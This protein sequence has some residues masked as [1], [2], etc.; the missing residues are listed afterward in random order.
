MHR[1]R[2]A[3]DGVLS[4][5]VPCVTVPAAAA[6]LSELPVATEPPNCRRSAGRTPGDTRRCATKL[7]TSVP[8]VETHAQETY[9][10]SEA[11]LS[12]EK[13]TQEKNPQI[14][15]RYDHGNRFVDEYRRLHGRVA[16]AVTPSPPY[17]P[18]HTSRRRCRLRPPGPIVGA[19]QRGPMLRGFAGQA[20]MTRVIRRCPGPTPT[21]VG[22]LLTGLERRP[23]NWARMSNEQHSDPGD[24]GANPGRP[25]GRDR[26]SFAGWADLVRDRKLFSV[27]TNTCDPDNGN[28]LWP[29]GQHVPRRR[30]VHGKETK[31]NAGIYC[32]THSESALL[33]N[34]L[35]A[36]TAHSVTARVR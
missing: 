25:G 13:D 16:A 33:I 5:V 3:A 21:A 24:H 30:H 11:P 29:R 28:Q 26:V 15:R 35:T 8:A 20:H 14:C 27:V 23:P 9:S 17:R 22:H 10:N 7:R 6:V 19:M 32:A 2:M 36:R 1:I 34:A 4:V 12:L 31:K 18:R